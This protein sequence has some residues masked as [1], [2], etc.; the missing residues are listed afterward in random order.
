[1]SAALSEALTAGLVF[2]FGTWGMK[3]RTRMTLSSDPMAARSEANCS[4]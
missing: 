2:C 4:L 1:V 3:T